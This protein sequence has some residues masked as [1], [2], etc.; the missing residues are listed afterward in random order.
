MVAIARL[1]GPNRQSES[2]GRH[3]ARGFEVRQ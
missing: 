1:D 3:F 2:H